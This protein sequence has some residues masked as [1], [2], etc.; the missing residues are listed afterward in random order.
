MQMKSLSLDKK[1]LNKNMSYLKV[2]EEKVC[3]RQVENHLLH[4]KT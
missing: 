1:L 4:T 2:I 3:V